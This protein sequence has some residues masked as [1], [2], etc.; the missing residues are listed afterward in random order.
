MNAVLKMS[1]PLVSLSRKTGIR[2]S[3][4]L[5][6]LPGVYVAVEARNGWS[7]LVVGQSKNVSNRAKLHRGGG[8]NPGE[9]YRLRTKMGISK[10]EWDR[11]KIT[12]FSLISDEYLTRRALIGLESTLIG[13][14]KPLYNAPKKYV[15][16]ERVREQVRAVR[17]FQKKEGK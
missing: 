16:I 17:W 12:I 2:P 14:L 13:Y 15:T 5:L 9:A 11:R 7:V 4:H 10:Q 8:N 6:E 1:G 3:Q